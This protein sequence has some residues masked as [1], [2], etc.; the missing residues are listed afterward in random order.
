MSKNSW[1]A[2]YLVLATV[3]IV[4]FLVYPVS[5]SKAQGPGPYVQLSGGNPVPINALT[6]VQTVSTTPTTSA[7]GQCTNADASSNWAYLQLFDTTGPITLGTTT[8][9]AFYG[10]PPG[11][12]SL[13]PI[14][15][16][17]SGI[18][19]AATTTTTGGTA[20]VTPINCTF[21]VR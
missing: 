15:N 17:Y 3:L 16:F 8:P 19:V 7:P 10:I 5:H 14:M 21:T 11:G 18:K 12:G 2:L 20:A 9:T 1:S 13:I 6:T 4:A